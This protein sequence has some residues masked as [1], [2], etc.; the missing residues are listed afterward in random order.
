[1]TTQ[2]EHTRTHAIV[3]TSFALFLSAL[4]GMTDAIGFMTAGDFISFMSGNTTRLAIAAGEGRSDAAIRLAAI[5]VLF[6][7][8]NSIGVIT[9]RFS[10]DRVWPLLFLVCAF[11]FISG[12][13]IG[14]DSVSIVTLIPT[15]LAMGAL[16]AA[17]ET[18]AG[19]PVSLT[20]VTGALSRFGKGLGR[21]MTGERKFGFLYQL[22]PWIGM[23]V[24][25]II[26]TLVQLAIGPA[27]LYVAALLALAL[28]LFALAIP[29]HWQ[30]AFL[31]R[32]R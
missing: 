32:D 2:I 3:G 10:K 7:A 31:G 14:A 16:N 26:G 27:S 12:A 23:L 5:L 4:A 28:A 8:G 15:I 9:V 29:H 21:L 24:G 17:L 18:V 1:M 22:A 11:L 19:Y 13:A 25:A 6:V 20:Y 30:T